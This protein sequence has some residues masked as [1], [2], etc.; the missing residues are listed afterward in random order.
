M[1][2][3]VRTR[4]LKIEEQ[5]TTLNDRKL[6]MSLTLMADRYSQKV[7]EFIYKC[8][9][10]SELLRT[11]KAIRNSGIYNK[12]SQVRRKI[13]EYPNGYVYDFIKTIMVPMYGPDWWKNNR[14]LNHELVKPWWVVDRL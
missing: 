7:Q 10:D 13:V 12:G 14:A 2:G 11:Y 5:Y 1:A 6:R 8:Y 4:Q 9:N 3:I